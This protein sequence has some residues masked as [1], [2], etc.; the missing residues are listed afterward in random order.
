MKPV[1]DERDWDESLDAVDRRIIELFLENSRISYSDLAAEVGLSRPGV[2]ER[3]ASLQ[4]RG[5]IERFTVDIPSDFIR[6]PLPAFFDIMFDP[7]SV[8][9]AAETIAAHPDIVTFYQMS[10]RNS[11]HVHGFF[12]SIE[13]V[14][15]FVEEFLVKIEGM[16]QVSTDFLLRRFKSDRV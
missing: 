2:T 9:N 10:A 6:K 12:G 3:V 15:R 4:R 14:G 7:S 5:V 16:Q 13:D 11:L 8:K 1:N